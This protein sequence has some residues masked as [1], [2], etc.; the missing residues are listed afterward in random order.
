[1]VVRQIRAQHLAPE[2]HA[3][4]L[5]TGSGVLAI[6]AAQ[7]GC[8]RVVAVDV[9]HRAVMATR[10]NAAL[11]RVRVRAVRGDLFA[12]VAGERFDLIVSNPPYIPS[13]HDEL[14]RHGLARAWEAGHDGR[15]ILDR[16]C[17][18]GHAHLNP[19][20]VMLL[21]HS[22][23]CGER[24]TLEALGKRGLQA[25]V[26]FRHLGKLGPLMRERADWLYEQG[27][28]RDPERQS[29]EMLVIKAERPAEP[30]SLHAA[31]RQEPPSRL[32]S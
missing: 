8:G 4:D 18:E 30:L 12:P 2:A 7:A 24:A 5:C 3:L 9:S 1:M 14:P 15:A 11:N 21:V 26:V 10:L 23:V 17:S 16:I 29:E 13:Q 32:R 25:E 19:G 6:A 31:T 28:L 22:E 27:L 20:G